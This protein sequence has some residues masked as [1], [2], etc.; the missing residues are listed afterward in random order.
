MWLRIFKLKRRVVYKHNYDFDWK[1]R[2]RRAARLH[3][4]MEIIPLHQIRGTLLRI[5][6]S[7]LHI[8]EC[9][10][11]RNLIKKLPCHK[12]LYRKLLSEKL[13]WICVYILMKFPFQQYTFVINF[14]TKLKLKSTER[15][16]NTVIYFLENISRLLF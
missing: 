4:I 15:C 13:L 8:L 16:T 9:Y 10:D 12:L 11:C 6:I 3:V 14:K 5:R 7:T 1:T 2:T